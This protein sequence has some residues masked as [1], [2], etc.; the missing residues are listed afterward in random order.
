MANGRGAARRNA[1][2]RYSARGTPRLRYNC[3]LLVTLNDPVHEPA[4]PVQRHPRAA[5]PGAVALSPLAPPP[6]EPPTRTRQPSPRRAAPAAPLA[7]AGKLSSRFAAS[8][9]SHARPAA[10]PPP[11]HQT[12]RVPFEKT[13]WAELQLQVPLDGGARLADWSKVITGV[14][15]LYTVHCAAAFTWQL[16]CRVLRAEQIQSVFCRL[17]SSSCK[18]AAATVLESS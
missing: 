9:S 15:F 2:G 4:A 16:Q 18:A 10:P 8:L 5:E 12:P 1:C 6:R 14:W 13:Q 17:R 7:A 3:T 11:T